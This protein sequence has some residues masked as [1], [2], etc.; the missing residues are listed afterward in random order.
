[1]LAKF[2]GQYLVT[3]SPNSMNDGLKHCNSPDHPMLRKARPEKIIYCYADPRLAVLSL[4]RRGL[5][6]GMQVK[7]R[8]FSDDIERYRYLVNERSSRV[9]SKEEFFNMGYDCFGINSFW[10]NWLHGIIDCPVLFLRYDS[11]WSNAEKIFDYVGLSKQLLPR[12]PCR[13]GRL[14][15]LD[16]ISEDNLA[17]LDRIYQQTIISMQQ[18]A[19]FAMRLP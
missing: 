2:F 6:D 12:F 3:N 9:K 11:I 17:A 13:R 16:N 1:M 14:T 15:S 19:P 5:A 10:N 7:L 8:Y 4:F 18:M